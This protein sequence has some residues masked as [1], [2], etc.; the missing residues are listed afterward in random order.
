MESPL[1]VRLACKL[2]AIKSHVTRIPI[3]V[4]IDID[5]SWPAQVAGHIEMLDDAPK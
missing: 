1:R 3:D 5:E 4:E 2:D